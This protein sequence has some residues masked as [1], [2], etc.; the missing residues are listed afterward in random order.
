MRIAFLAPFALHPKGT[1]RWRILPLAQALAAAGHTVRVIIPP[2]DWP[3]HSGRRW[4]AQGVEVVN[5][6]V[7]AGPEV[8]QALALAARVRRAALD[9]RPEIIHACKPVGVSGLAAAA[10]LRVPDAPPVVVDADDWE[11]GWAAAQGRSAAWQRLVQWQERFLLRHAPAVT[12]ASRWLQGW[13]VAHR[14]GLSSP[15]RAGEEVFYLPNGATAGSTVGGGP[16]PGDTRRVLLYTRFAEHSPAQVWAV[17]QGVLAAQPAAQLWVAGRGLQGEEAA[18]LALARADGRPATLRLLGWLP[19][20]SRLGL[21][22]AVDAAMLPVA[23]TPLNRAKCPMRLAELLA[24]GVPVATQAVGEYARYVAD[25]VGGL[26]APAGDD[27]ALAAAVVRLLGD[28]EL[29]AALSRGAVTH[30]QAHFDRQELARVALRAYQLAQ[31]S[32]AAV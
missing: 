17:W 30:M 13:V 16:R 2:Y 27:P 32:P 14:R 31:H 21:F 29:R 6:A 5:V 23:D 11:A 28:A 8:G 7:P 4:W 12:V 19:A 26:L 9:W 24:A 22:A 15:M 20:A 3:A 1:T 10:L 18:L 25:G